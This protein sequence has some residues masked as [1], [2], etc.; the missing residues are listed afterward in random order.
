MTYRATVVGPCEHDGMTFDLH[1]EN[2]SCW[3]CEIGLLNAGGR[4]ITYPLLRTEPV[5]FELGRKDNILLT[6]YYGPKEST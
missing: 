1:I 3:P 2:E 6:A 4:E 5:P